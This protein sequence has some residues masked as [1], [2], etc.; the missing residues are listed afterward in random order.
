MPTVRLPLSWPFNPRSANTTKDQHRVN[1]V[2]EMLGERT[3][4][5]KRPGILTYQAYTAGVGQGMTFFNGGLYSVISDRVHQLGA[6][7]SG[8][9]G[10]QWQAMA[11]ALW[12]VRS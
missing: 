11:N 8:A 1:V 2:D 12:V 9:S 4:T 7:A 3:F 5:L 6:A 10:S